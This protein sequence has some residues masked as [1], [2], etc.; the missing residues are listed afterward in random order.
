M[1]VSVS[2]PMMP[3]H[4]HEEAQHKED[5]QTE[6]SGPVSTNKQSN[7]K[8]LIVAA[9]RAI[10]KTLDGLPIPAAKGCIGLVLKVIEAADVA[11][12]NRDTLKDLQEQY[13]DLIEFLKSLKMPDTPDTV[14]KEVKVFE[15]KLQKLSKSW[16]PCLTKPRIW[17]RIWNKIVKLL[18]AHD[19]HDMLNK[20]LNKTNQAINDFLLRLEVRNCIL[21]YREMIKIRHA[22]VISTICHAAHASYKSASADGGRTCLPGTRKRVLTTIEIWALHPDPRHPPIFWLNGLAGIGKTT[23]ARTIASRLDAKHRLGGT[24]VFLRADDQRKDGNLLFPTLALQL[25]SMYPAYKTRLAEEVDSNPSCV[26]HS[27]TVQFESLIR[28]PLSAVAISEPLI[29]ILDA[30]DECQSNNLAEELLS[31][32]MSE[33]KSIPF[34]RV[35]I[36]SRPEGHIRE[37]LGLG[38]TI[39]QQQT[40]VLHQDMAIQAEVEGDIRLFLQVSLQQIWDKDTKHT[41][42]V[43]PPSKDL[44]TLVHQSGKLFIYAATAVRFIGGNRSLNLEIQLQNLLKVKRKHIPNDNVEPYMHLDQL[45]LNILETAFTGIPDTKNNYY[46][47]RFQ[48]IVGSIVLMQKPLPLEAFANFLH[49]YTVD[50]IKQTLYYLHSIFIVPDEISETLRTYHLSFPNFITHADRCTNKNAYINSQTQEKFV[51][52][53]CLAMIEKYFGVTVKSEQQHTADSIGEDINKFEDVIEHPQD[54]DQFIHT[55]YS[56]ELGS[57]PEYDTQ[58]DPGDDLYEFEDASMTAEIQYS[59]NHWC[60]HLI[61]IKCGDSETTKHLAQFVKHYFL[62]WLH[63]RI[64]WIL[65]TLDG[66]RKMRLAEDT[67]NIMHNAH[68]W[69]VANGHDSRRNLSTCQAIERSAHNTYQ[70]L[71][72]EYHMK[73][74]FGNRITDP[75]PTLSVERANMQENIRVIDL[76]EKWRACQTDPLTEDGV[77]AFREFCVRELTRRGHRDVSRIFSKQPKAIV[78]TQV[79]R[80]DRLHHRLEQTQANVVCPLVGC[81]SQFMRMHSLNLHLGAHIG[82]TDRYCKGCDNYFSA[83][84]INRHKMTCSRKK[85]ST[86]QEKVHTECASLSAIN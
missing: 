12:N 46:S 65:S 47:T 39:S 32:L 51:F 75:P 53:R 83:S 15:K 42:T 86:P 70:L 74:R 80:A 33:V 69:L 5:A 52:F 58:S 29:L 17:N 78:G 37:A 48:N 20:F 30:L 72:P 36:T 31:V 9:L 77:V 6:D 45:Y 19:E 25:S 73:Y 61:N 40:L 10:E 8:P 54:G 56:R 66:T 59:C 64:H 49:K 1:T 50:D 79:S 35:F 22:A 26:T 55:D 63:Q 85:N 82:L 60:S 68:R 23:I 7:W 62:K 16:E 34:L 4:N 28:R 43:W 44:E 71:F 2:P 11:A 24:F 76:F 67:F 21:N 14:R 57:G 13:E 18:R 84:S 3:A 41:A 27:P 38:D 81:G